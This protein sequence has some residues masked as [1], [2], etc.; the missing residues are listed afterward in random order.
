[1]PE[2]PTTIEAE[3]A[4]DAHARLGEGPIWD[5][6]GGRLV[7]V[8]IHA[9]AVHLFEPSSGFDQ[10]LQAGQHIG[11]AAARSPTAAARWRFR[12]R[13]A[14]CRTACAWTPKAASGWRSCAA[15]RCSATRPTAG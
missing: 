3:L 8:D 7:W 4:L 9:E 2:T 10:M 12:A 5:A 13:R 11:A 6:E 1:M 14:G 15:A